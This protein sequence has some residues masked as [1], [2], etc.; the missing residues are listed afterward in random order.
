MYNDIYSA[1]TDDWTPR[2]QCHQQYNR[3]RTID[4]PP[5]RLQGGA[6][7]TTEPSMQH[8]HHPRYSVK[9]RGPSKE[10]DPP[11]IIK[12]YKL[13]PYTVEQERRWQESQKVK[14]KKDDDNN[15]RNS[16]KKKSKKEAPSINSMTKA[17]L[18]QNMKWQHPVVSL[19][20][21]TV[22]AN[23]KLA[24]G[25]ES[26]EQVQARAC[27]NDITRQALITKRDTQEFLGE[28]IEALFNTGLTTEDRTILSAMCPQVSS[29]YTST[30][31][32]DG[33]EEE[34]EG[35]DE[36]WEDDN[37]DDDDDDGS[38]TDPKTPFKQFYSILSAHVYSRKRLPSTVVGRQV[39]S[40]ISR[41]AE[42]QVALPVQRQWTTVY[43][44]SELLQSASCQ[45]FVEIK[46][47]YITGSKDLEKKVNRIGCPHTLRIHGF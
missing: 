1:A 42:L 34:D 43:S 18:V 36:K 12:E 19:K 33:K 29:S 3:Y 31:N 32:T 30:S 11:E 35:D 28:F 10:Q 23:S 22:S 17:Q 5:P 40:L 47:L 2:H 13:K 45:L 24:L 39:Q 25:S 16:K 41:A 46:K 14:H 37:D 26:N 8:C 21:G 20:I 9:E 4:Q 15:N 38:K 6:A 44:T 7:D 27:I